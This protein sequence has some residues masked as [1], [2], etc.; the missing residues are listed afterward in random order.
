MLSHAADGLWC[1]HGPL[2]AG[3]GTVKILCADSVS[4]RRTFQQA[5][6][7]FYAALARSVPALRRYQQVLATLRT[8]WPPR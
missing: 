2:T 4:A 1:N 6:E 5:G 3:G 7:I 8:D